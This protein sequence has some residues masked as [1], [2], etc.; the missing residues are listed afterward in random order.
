MV[1][2]LAKALA[3]ARLERLDKVKPDLRRTE[4]PVDFDVWRETR[5]GREDTTLRP[6]LCP[7]RRPP[8]R[9]GQPQLDLTQKLQDVFDRMPLPAHA[10]LPSANGKTAQF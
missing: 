5:A 3:V 2:A 8:L 4:L 10:K 1:I 9:D 7:G 6:C